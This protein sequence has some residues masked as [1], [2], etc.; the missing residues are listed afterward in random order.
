LSADSRAAL[1][2]AARAFQPVSTR[3]FLTD[4]VREKL[5]RR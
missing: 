3:R 1:T 2:D 5:E 4:M